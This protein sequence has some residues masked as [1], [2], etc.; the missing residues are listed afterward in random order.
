[1]SRRLLTLASLAFFLVPACYPAEPAPISLPTPKKAGGVSIEAALAARRSIR[2]YT[3]QSLTVAEV[4]QL[5]WAAQGVTSP[6]GKRTAPSAMH[7][8]P[9]EIAVVAQ[10]VDGLPCGAYRYVPATH[11]LQL[12]ITAK[13]GAALLAGSTSQPQVQSAAAVFVI[14]AVYERM[15]SGAKNRT[16]TDYEAGLASENLLLEG[17]ALKLGAVVTGGIDPSSVRE[18]VRLTGGEQ[19]IVIIPVGHPAT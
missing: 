9:L 1:M 12:L 6:D 17:V 16:W 2:S 7:R 10:N 18:A 8:Y 4:G 14:T 3:S 19:V 11:S 15:G 5:L 13:P